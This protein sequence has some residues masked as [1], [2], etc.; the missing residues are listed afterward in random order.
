M[1][2]VRVC[3]GGV[4]VEREGEV[5]GRG[6]AHSMV[7]FVFVKALLPTRHCHRRQMQSISGQCF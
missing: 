4:Q 3:Q 6:G 2:C 5:E 7:V 1:G